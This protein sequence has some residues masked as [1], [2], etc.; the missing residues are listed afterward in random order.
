MKNDDISDVMDYRPALLG[1]WQEACRHIEIDEF[2]AIVFKMLTQFMPIGQLL[3]RRVDPIRPCVDTVAVGSSAPDY[4]LP[5][6][7]SECS[8]RKIEEVEAWCRQARIARRGAPGWADAPV[9]ILL[10]VGVRG[11]VLV[12]PLP[13]P[14]GPGGVLA[15]IAEENASFTSQ[16]A[17]IAEHLLEPISTALANDRRLREIA[18]M[19]AAA[20]A[21]KSS[22]LSRLGRKRLGDDPVVGANSGLRAVME[23]VGLVAKSDAPVLIL[24]E[25]GT[26]KE[27]I[28]R[29]IHNHSPRAA[30]P[31]LRVNCGAIP[32]D[33]I[34]S[35]L[36]G[37]ERGAFTGAV[38]TRQGWFERADGGTLLLDE[39]GELPLAAQVRLLRILQDGWLE[40]VGG[41][42]PMHVDVRIVAAT[43]RDLAAMVNE[44]RF[45]EDLWYRIAVFPII[46]PPLRE[47]IQ[48]IAELARHFAERAAARFVLSLALPTAEDIEL[49]A[50]YP[51]PGN[52]RELAA[53]IDRA[54]ILG[55]GRRLEV[56]KALGVTTEMPAA[57]VGGPVI[58]TV[59]AATKLTPRSRFQTLDD[60]VKQHIESALALAHGRIEGRRGAA[61]LLDI[62]PH[63]LRARMRKLKIDW[64]QF[65]RQDEIGLL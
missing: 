5:Q 27:L 55:D 57:S 48:D 13:E 39:V 65:R 21:E 54:A 9:E 20:E 14:N 31:F 17:E 49:L 16:H 12:G 45:R 24:G 50:A 62:N 23:R 34:D 32:P 59:S 58:G 60:A 4:L 1:L 41:Q 26:G 25:T 19:R 61:A 44:G 35:Q 10:P 2:A 63:T 64:A 40:K 18:A 15:L 47:R 3:V 28:A 6:T 8:A 22:L 56:A 51:W 42:T 52:I 38:D 46:L 11:D 53:V 36:F 7:R 37:H 30:G 43:H 33:L 29:M